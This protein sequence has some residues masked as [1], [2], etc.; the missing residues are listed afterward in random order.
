[1]YSENKIFAIIKVRNKKKWTKEEDIKLIKLAE[2]NKEKHWKEISKNFQNKN[3]LQCF[4]RYKRIKPGIIKGTWSKEE[5]EKI[6]SLVKIYG[7]SWSKL[8]KIM[9]SRNGKQIRDRFINVLDPE[10]KKGKFSYKEDKKIKE[11]YLKYGPRWATIARGLPNRTPDMI[12]NRFHSSIKKYLHQKNFLSKCVGNSKINKNEQSSSKKTSSELL[13]N[14]NTDILNKFINLNSFA[15]SNGNYSNSNS[16]NLLLLDK[17]YPNSFSNYSCP[18]Q[19]SNYNPCIFDNKY[20][21]LQSNSTDFDNRVIYGFNLSNSQQNKENN[22]NK[23]A[24]ISIMKNQEFRN[25]QH[26]QYNKNF[27]FASTQ[28]FNTEFA[29]KGVIFNKIASKTK[30]K[31][32]ENNI[33]DDV[34]RT[35]SNSDFSEGGNEKKSFSN[36]YLR[37][38]C[39]NLPLH[40]NIENL[41]EHPDEQFPNTNFLDSNSNNNAAYNNSHDN[42]STRDIKVYGTANNPQNYNSLVSRNANKTKSNYDTQQRSLMIN[43]KNNNNNKNTNISNNNDM[44]NNKMKIIRKNKLEIKNENPNLLIDSKLIYQASIS[45]NTE[46]LNRTNSFNFNAN[47]ILKNVAN[48]QQI[49][50]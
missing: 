23:D 50:A 18:I 19:E 34:N 49:K 39:K 31:S 14:S 43:N 45:N 26:L 22:N 37:D 30:R 17:N 9:K 10:V 15:S 20:N 4:S 24:A 5:D 27:N 48:Q 46:N 7:K 21:Q 6:L 35:V 38:G 12:K 11:L 42:S 32:S 2:K 13:E 1:M 41:F 8:A 29:N 25:C 44:D 28:T 3:P 40:E 16:K 36:L 33:I 47:N